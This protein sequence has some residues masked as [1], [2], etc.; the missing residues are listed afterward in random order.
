MRL[1]NVYISTVIQTQN[2]VIGKFVIGVN[3]MSS[4]KCCFDVMIYLL[5]RKSY[6]VG[7]NLIRVVCPGDED[8][9]SR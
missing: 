5:S 4:I 8:V 6:D 3:Y 9:L 2:F 7:V 1:S